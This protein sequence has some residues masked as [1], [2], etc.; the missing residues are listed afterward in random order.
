MGE[1]KTISM[2]ELRRG[3]PRLC[4]SPHRAFKKCFKCPQYVSSSGKPCDSRIENTEA[5]GLRRRIAQEKDRHKARVQRL[6]KKLE[7]IE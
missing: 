3:N 1:H 5:D 7:A 6:E 4:L 2:S